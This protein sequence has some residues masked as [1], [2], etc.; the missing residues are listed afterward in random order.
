MQ[1]ARYYSINK[2]V[3][4][5]IYLAFK[6]FFKENANIMKEFMIVHFLKR[7]FGLSK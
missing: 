3:Q 1:V 7:C 4:W 5:S 6:R 2:Q